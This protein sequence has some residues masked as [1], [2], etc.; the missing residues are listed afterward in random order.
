MVAPVVLTYN[1]IA[2]QDKYHG[3]MSNDSRTTS[4]ISCPKQGTKDPH[5]VPVQS[6]RREA[7][8]MTNLKTPLGRRK[9]DVA[10]QGTTHTTWKNQQNCCGAG[11]RARDLGS[12]TSYARALKRSG[13]VSPSRCARAQ[14]RRR[15][16]VGAQCLSAEPKNHTLSGGLKSRAHRYGGLSPSPTL[17]RRPHCR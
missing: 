4:M 3:K 9:I 5:H 12:Q 11:L 15:L 1:S 2:G 16:S 17:P 13:R 6:K 8:G 14:P 10:A 7:A